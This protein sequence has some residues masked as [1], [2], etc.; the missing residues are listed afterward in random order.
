[1]YTVLKPDVSISSTGEK[2]KKKMGLAS[3]PKPI[4]LMEFTL[5]NRKE[6][7]ICLP[8]CRLACTHSLIVFSYTRR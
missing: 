2:K 6:I 3:T 1:M 4:S 7:C 8:E 5:Q